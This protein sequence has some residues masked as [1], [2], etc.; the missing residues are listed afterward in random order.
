MPS[1]VASHA[2]QPCLLCV[3]P[4]FGEFLKVIEKQKERA[5]KFDDE[6]D[7]SAWVAGAHIRSLLALILRFLCVRPYS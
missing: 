5:A 2:V 7:M 4:D 6:S 3:G 1:V